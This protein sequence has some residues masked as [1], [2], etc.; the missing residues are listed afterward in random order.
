MRLTLPRAMVLSLVVH[1]TV[2]GW[3]GNRWSPGGRVHEPAV[4]DGAVEVLLFEWEESERPVSSLDAAA[5][6]AAARPPTRASGDVPLP[7]ITAVRRLPPEPTPR[8][9]GARA[10]APPQSARTV[11]GAHGP[12]RAPGKKKKGAPL[13]AKA[14]AGPAPAAEAEGRDAEPLA[15]LRC[16]QPDY[17]LAARRN[18][19]AGR[20]EIDVEVDPRGIPRRAEVRAS[21]GHLVLDRAATSA[22]LRSRFAPRRQTSAPVPARGRIAYRFRLVE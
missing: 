21:S 18:G 19:W 6:T 17:P 16:V 5:V 8:S 22:A 12:E 4:S 1:T 11:R 2:L 9:D 15:C 13:L 3:L 20:V 14:T 7:A 10:H